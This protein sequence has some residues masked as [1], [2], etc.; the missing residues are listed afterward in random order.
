MI[1]D[2]A[3]DDEDGND[4]EYAHQRVVFAVIDTHRLIS[5]TVISRFFGP[6]A[7]LRRLLK[8][9]VIN[10]DDSSFS[11][12]VTNTSSADHRRQGQD[13]E[14]KE[15]AIHSRFAFLPRKRY[16]RHR[17]GAHHQRRPMQSGI[18]LRR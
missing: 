2:D 10:G 3:C 11:K 13:E 1:D 4:Q 5:I 8:S 18:L 6:A 12:T 9:I 7:I 15:S 16:H 14:R 17:F